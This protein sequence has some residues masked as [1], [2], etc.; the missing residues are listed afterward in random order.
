MKTRSEA[1]HQWFPSEFIGRLKELGQVYK[2][3]PFDRKAQQQLLGLLLRQRE[4]RYHI[5]IKITGEAE[6]FILAQ[7]EINELGVRGL[8]NVIANMLDK[9]L[10]K[11]G[12]EIKQKESITIKLRHNQLKIN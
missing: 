10:D 4:E 11:F 7:S 6:E 9:E 5:T 3:K 8:K 1:L 2:F 12:P